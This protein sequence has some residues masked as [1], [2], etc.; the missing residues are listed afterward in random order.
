METGKSISLLALV[1]VL[2]PA[3]LVIMLVHRPIPIEKGWHFISNYCFLCMMNNCLS[4]ILLIILMHAANILKVIIFHFQK[5]LN[6]FDSCSNQIKIFFHS[7]FQKRLEMSLWRNISSLRSTTSK[8]TSS[9]IIRKEEE[10]VLA[11]K[12]LPQEL[13]NAK[14]MFRHYPNFHPGYQLFM[15]LSSVCLWSKVIY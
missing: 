12:T 11:P 15:R 3:V 14:V 9:L 13:M 8:E 6:N 4:Y 5:K 10:E 2:L 7:I 1:A